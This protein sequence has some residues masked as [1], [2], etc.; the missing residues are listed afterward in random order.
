[1]TTS[2]VTATPY[3]I[4]TMTA[5]G[6]V[7]TIVNLNNFYDCIEV[8]KHSDPN[9]GV[10]YAEYGNNKHSQVCKGVNTK[11]KFIRVNGKKE[12]SMKRFDNS[13]TLKIKFN[14]RNAV[15]NVKLFKNGKVQ[16]TGVKSIEQ[17]KH[18]VDTVVNMMLKFQ[19][20]K[21][22]IKEITEGLL[23]TVIENIQPIEEEISPNENIVENINIV[24]SQD[25]K[26]H[27]INSDFKVNFEIRRDLLYKVF[28]NEFDVICT[29]EPCI[30]PGVKVQYFL[31]KNQ[32][33]ITD[34]RKQGVCCCSPVCD[35]KGD[36]FTTTKC[37]K[38][39]ISVFQSGCILI[40][41]VTMVQHINIAYSF[42]VELLKINESKIKRI[43]LELP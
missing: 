6:S 43:K 26:I 7:G 32:K 31:N 15:I 2:C 38:I 33:E 18:A 20:S 40:T 24:K 3:R 29:Y 34:I 14:E 23:E 19:D 25:F 30:Y 9:E 28:L 16:M 21:N 42:I 12:I 36:G 27:L 35:G 17:G 41:G 37:K 10:I 22:K 8:I 1:M 4:S 13:V 5:T 39:T 11:K